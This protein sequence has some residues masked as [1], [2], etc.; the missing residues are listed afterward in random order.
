MQ[1]KTI[2]L[3]TAALALLAVPA[4]AQEAPQKHHRHHATAASGSIDARIDALEAQIREL[5]RDQAAQQQATAAM[6]APSDQTVSQAQ[7]EALQNQ[8]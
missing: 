4:A 3:G 7:F 6:P 8:V 1:F 5:K 2:L